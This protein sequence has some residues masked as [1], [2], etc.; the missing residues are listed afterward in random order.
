MRASAAVT[1]LFLA[2]GFALSIAITSIK[3]ALSP[4]ASVMLT[5]FCR[6]E[7]DAAKPVAPRA[8]NPTNKAIAHEFVKALS[9]AL[10]STMVMVGVTTAT[11]S[12][13]A[14][15]GYVRFI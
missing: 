2:S 15:S 5:L 7:R 12:Q 11:T 9:S 13:Y 10:V 1:I 6:S 14:F 8:E 4:T 3:Y